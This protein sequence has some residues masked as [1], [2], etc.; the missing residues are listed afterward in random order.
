ME[1]KYFVVSLPRSGTSSISKMA[2]I[3]G[4][5]QKHCPSLYFSHLLGRNDFNFYSDTPIYAPSTIDIICADE[6]SDVKFIF[7]NRNFKDIFQSWVNVNLYGDYLHILKMY[8][9]NRNNMS[10][11][12]LLDY[13]SH[14]DAFNGNILNESNY[15]EVFNNHKEMI[16]NKIVGYNR[17]ILIYNFESGWKPF[18]DFLGVNVPNVEIP[19]INKSKMFEAIV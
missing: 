15:Q 10:P 8:N 17:P 13:E 7:I 3:V 2:Y 6:E 5:K 18:C 16:I 11:S 9:S 1:T 12:M 4:M 19:I 14:Y